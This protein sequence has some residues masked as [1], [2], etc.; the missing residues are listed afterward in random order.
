[1]SALG[2]APW[3]NR[4]RTPGLEAL[5]RGFSPW[6]ADPDGTVVIAQCGLPAAP[7]AGEPVVVM[8]GTDVSGRLHLGHLYNLVCASAVAARYR[9]QLVVTINEAESMLSRRAT[10]AGALASRQAI[11]RTLERDGV[12][13]HFRL[14]DEVLLLLA[15]ALFSE[16]NARGRSAVLAPHYGGDLAAADLLAVCVMASVPAVLAQSAGARHVIAVYG[17]DELPHLCLM[18]ELYRSGWYRETLLRRGMHACPAFGFVATRLVPG[19]PGRKMSKSLPE[20]A[21]P[22]EGGSA[23][24]AELTH[25][26]AAVAA[27]AAS[28]CDSRADN[29]LLRRIEAVLRSEANV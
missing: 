13:V 20:D 22:F 17:H 29:P 21:I 18:E 8:A 1:V 16:L 5:A 10:V 15:F 7:T 24:N 27:L 4:L 12:A 14:R 26:L 19:G 6:D 3:S 11:S 25:E 9:G 28:V 2:E 23:L